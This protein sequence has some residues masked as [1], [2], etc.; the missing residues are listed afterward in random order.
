M[1][2]IDFVGQ[3]FPGTKSVNDECPV[4][5]ADGLWIVRPRRDRQSLA[6]EGSGWCVGDGGDDLAVR[7]PLPECTYSEE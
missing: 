3:A 1:G 4:C 2:A 5:G 6:D 7:G